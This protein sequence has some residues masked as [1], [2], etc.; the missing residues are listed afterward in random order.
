MVRSVTAKPGPR[1]RS[2][3]ASRLNTL[4]GVAARVRRIVNSVTV[5]DTSSPAQAALQASGSRLSLPRTIRPS[6]GPVSDALPP[7]RRR[8]AWT[9][10]TTS[11]GLNGLTT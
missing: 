8:M 5:S 11:R 6:A 3:M 9:R 4:V 7:V 2:M 10:A 1:R